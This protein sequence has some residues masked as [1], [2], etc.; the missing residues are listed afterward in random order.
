MQVIKALNLVHLCSTTST[1]NYYSF[2]KNGTPIQRGYNT[3]HR[4][5]SE[6]SQNRQLTPSTEKAGL[7]SWLL[8]F[9]VC[10]LSI[11]EKWSFPLFC[12]VFSAV[13]RKASKTPLTFLMFTS[14]IS[15]LSE[16][17]SVTCPTPVWTR[18]PVILNTPFC[19]EYRSKIPWTAL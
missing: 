8:G 7:L 11:F 3:E 13:S 9:L 19:F 14:D 18:V 5:Q 6:K 17:S 10:L 12:F 4:R 15:Y 16:Y 1:I 2:I